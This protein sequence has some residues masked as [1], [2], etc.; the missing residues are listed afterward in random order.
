MKNAREILAERVNSL[1]GEGL[2]FRSPAEWAQR[3]V[4][5]GLVPDAASFTRQINRIRNAEVNAQLNTL[6]HLAKS[7]GVALPWLVGGDQNDNLS[8]SARKLIAEIAALDRAD[9]LRADVIFTA[10]AVLLQPS[11]ESNSKGK[12]A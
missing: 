8:E 6:E 10:I 12:V 2:R 1:I 3:A 7:A 5:M 9:R 11:D 4:T